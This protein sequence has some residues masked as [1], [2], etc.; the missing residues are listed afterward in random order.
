MTIGR[1]REHSWWRHLGVVGTVALGSF[2]VTG[3]GESAVAPD[4]PIA[5]PST[6]VLLSPTQHL[7]RAS[8]ALRG[9]RPSVEE[10]TLVTAQP[11]QLP[12][13]IDRYLASPEFGATIRDLHNES[14]LLRIELEKFGF[15]S[16]EKLAD[17][18]AT[19]TVGAYEEPLRL[20][21]DIVM[22]DQPYTRIVTADYTMANAIVATIWG[23]QH[24]GPAEQWQRT[25]WPDGR[26]AAGILSSSIMF[27]RWRST[28]FNFN[29][30]RANMISRALL[31]H[32]F[33]TSD[34]LVDTS[35]DLSDPDK[36]S[37]AVVENASCAGCHQTLDPL[38]SYL[39]AFRGQVAPGTINKYPVKFY[40][41]NNESDWNAATGRVPLFFGAPASGLGGL[42][43]AVA[44]D[45]RFARCAAV[46]FASFMTE[47]DADQLS[48][49]WVARLQQQFVADGY[50]AKK[51]A[52][53]V[54]L[55]DE[56]RVASDTDAG[57]AETTV[58]LL[59]VRPEQLGRMLHGI[60]GFDWVS[61][62]TTKMRQTVLG[63]T[64]LLQS[65]FAGYRVLAGGI[66]SYFVTS[67]VHT[68]NATSSL[69]MRNAAA[70]A[71]SFVVEHDA[72]A[73]AAQRTLFT[74]SELTATDEASVRQQIVQLHA[75]IFSELV[76]A[77]S[78]EATETWTL[79]RDALAISSDA[80]QAWKITLT[81]MLSDMR[82][83][84]Y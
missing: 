29:R 34:V 44:S 19:Q 65:D 16:L 78:P 54:V 71:A 37:H 45:P 61:N 30:G 72:A 56:F 81:G 60:T 32:D 42:G 1:L 46:H 28:G 74:A 24:A 53:A 23:L 50:N 12:A 48:A 49:A 39:F 43:Q 55:S 73:A 27:Q 20:I 64:D 40:A 33:L 11:E 25:T 76:A 5:A 4:A 36:V 59:K 2:S 6:K 35:V 58:G 14:L 63:T 26:P 80:K 9:V 10:L 67:P 47:V 7:T 8:M 66:D 17:A 84:F 38:G 52:K 83:L 15:P 3:C 18:T 13:I 51:L 62:L 70:S 75:R 21:E 41:A 82:A 57:R 31:C 77:D 22:T 69:V 68:M 79:F